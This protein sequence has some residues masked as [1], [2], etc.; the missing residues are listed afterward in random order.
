MVFA[1]SRR[2]GVNASTRTDDSGAFRME[3][4]EDG[5]FSVTVQP[6]PGAG[7]RSVSRTVAVAG[8]TSQD[9][10]VPTASLSGVVIA[11]ATK[12]PLEG[13]R[14]GASLQGGASADGGRRAGGAS[15]DTN[16]RW[17]L[18]DVEPGTWELVFR[19]DGYLE[20]TRNAVAS[21]A[22]GDGGTV[23]LNRGEG[24]E[25]RVR[26]GLYQIPLRGVSVRVRDGAGGS[27]LSTFVSLDGDGKG[28]V[29]SL[30]PGRYSLVVESGGYAAQRIEGVVV[31]A[32][33]LP[34]A[35]T[36]GGAVEIRAGEAS[37]AKGSA[38]LHDAL[39]RPHPL[40]AFGEEGRVVLP[41][42]GVA[43]LGNLAPGTYTLAVEGV[44]PKAF[45]VTEGG[46]TV[47]ELP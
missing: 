22:G 45:T 43:T 6:A 17:F 31:P 42:S 44:A 21:E 39:G 34:V 35:L 9:F 20:E 32:A 30:K 11:A 5:E 2:G 7:G 10:E 28:E 19:R 18:D 3:G 33:P 47:V 36:P 12:Q 16:G 8:E 27:V 40:R 29:P 38:T 25:L 37:R 23:E 13:V 14:V 41:A 46:R 4:L 26:D 15:T 24:L 1:G